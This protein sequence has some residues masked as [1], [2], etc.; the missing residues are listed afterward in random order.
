MKLGILMDPIRNINVQKDSSFAM[1]LASQ[2][3]GWD[4]YYME[5]GDLFIRDGE[6]WGRMSK[7]AVKD[8]PSDWFSQ[9]EK[10][11]LPLTDLDII[12]MR[13]DPP[14]DMQYIYITQIL[15]L[16]Q[17]AG[18]YVVN[19]PAALRDFNEKL[20]INLFPGFIAPTLVSS[21][22]GQLRE[23]VET[24]E[25]I[26]LKPLYG[27]GGASIFR[28]RKNDTNINVII[29][30]LTLHGSHYIMAQKYIPEI[31][32]GDKRILLINGEPVPYALARI[33]VSG[34]N[35]GNLAAGGISKGVELSSRDR[36]ICSAVA[37][38]LLENGLIFVGLDVIGNHLTEINITSPTCIREL[39][40]I[41]SLNI[42]RDLM[43]A[44]E[45][46]LVSSRPGFR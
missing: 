20:F 42:A 11:T 24:Y 26:I 46:N 39:D 30:T 8:D 44:I 35:R 40:K 16:A 25:D 1:L 33:P 31:S 13:K 14:V 22:P 3:L 21:S 29:E 45:K 28:A 12:L 23:F 19:N 6:S 9:D 38:V 5:A 41:Y 17:A 36:E 10:K 43:L 4:N 18:V 2:S 7:L 32:E 34:E 37:P 27:M 15:E